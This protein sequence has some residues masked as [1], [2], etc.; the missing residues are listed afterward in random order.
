MKML[1]F[2]GLYEK[3]IDT[4]EF[5]IQLGLSHWMEKKLGGFLRS[6]VYL[7]AERL[8]HKIQSFI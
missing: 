7:D 2:L 4:L 8:L 1:K 5:W 3:S 6:Q